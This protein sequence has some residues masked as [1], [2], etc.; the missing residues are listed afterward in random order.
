MDMGRTSDARQRLIAS[1]RQLI[2]QR[3]Y[4]RVGVS[5]L[6]EHADVKKGS[7]YYF[8]ASKEK[9]AEAMVD[10]FWVDYEARM[11]ASLEGDGP[12][13]DRLRGFL[14]ATYLRHRGL[15]S[16]EGCVTG[17]ML[18]NLAL[19]L[20]TTA[21]AVRARLVVALGAIAEAVAEVV[22]EAMS[23]GELPQGDPHIKGEQFLAYLEG[24]ILLAKV[25]NDPEVIRRLQWGAFVLLGLHPEVEEQP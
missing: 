15:A 10:S 3:G 17:C 14:I 11:R 21:E 7:F 23:A 16:I 12:P 20:A 2:G 8:F 22:A 18:G 9:L 6:C 1:A 25:R 24:M 13:L 19:E 4:H 5:E